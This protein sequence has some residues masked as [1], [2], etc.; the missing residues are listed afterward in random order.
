MPGFRQRHHTD[1]AL[2][3]ILSATR[4]RRSGPG[5]WQGH[6]PAHDDRDPS[7]SIAQ[8]TDGTILIY[9]H[10]G[11]STEAV[12]E[13]LG[14]EWRDLF[15]GRGRGSFSHPHP[16]RP[17]LRPQE[18]DGELPLGRWR[19]WWKGATPGHPLLRS[20]LKARGLEL[21]PPPTLR[22]A[23][24]RDTPVM[25][26]QVLRG[27]RLVGLHLTFLNPD[28]TRR[29]HKRLV[30]GSRAK[31]GAI[32]LYPPQSDLP[33][34]IAEG[35]ETALAVRQATGWPV[36]AAI[37]AN[38]M[39]HVPLPQGVKEV[40]VAADH[41]RAGLRAAQELAQR[42]VGLGVKVRLAVPPKEGQDWLDVL[43]EVGA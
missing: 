27:E 41:D 12:L 13:S 6:C 42:L 18:E 20:Y 36:W 26:A 14:L 37:S 31:G 38:L 16:P 8:G 32:P 9:C 17:H 39:P 7:F 10:A 23:L 2:Q 29:T 24:W 21:E 40:V 33:L 25:L 15:P 30:E 28:G 35:I 43:R 11:C 34:A 4:A 3:V 5:S 19:R 1:D 22:L